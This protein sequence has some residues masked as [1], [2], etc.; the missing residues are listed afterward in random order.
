MKNALDGTTSE[1]LELQMPKYD[2][3]GIYIK[4]TCGFI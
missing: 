2:F 3:N 1:T 4:I